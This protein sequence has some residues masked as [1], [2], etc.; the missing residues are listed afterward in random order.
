[1]REIVARTRL[2]KSTILTL[3]ESLRQ[4]GY[5]I[6]LSDG[7]YPF[8]PTLFHLGYLY[9]HSFQL[10]DHVMP[11][12]SFVTLTMI[13][14]MEHRSNQDSFQMQASASRRHDGRA[15]PAAFDALKMLA[16]SH[17]PRGAGSFSVT[18]KT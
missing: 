4:Y 14:K 5:I 18:F 11:A 9:H 7:S 6:Q 1:M 2:H 10:E 3:I 12:L 16:P 17:Y 8:G 15:L 13:E